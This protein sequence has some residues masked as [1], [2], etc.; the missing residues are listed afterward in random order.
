MWWKLT[1][2]GVGVIVSGM[3]EWEWVSLSEKDRETHRR[4]RRLRACLSLTDD[5]EPHHLDVFG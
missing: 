1:Q 3:N 2:A 4:Q 5:D